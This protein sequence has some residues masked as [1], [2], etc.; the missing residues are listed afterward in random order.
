MLKRTLT[1]LVGMLIFIPVCIFSGTLVFPIAVAVVTVIAV[2]EMMNCIGA[3]KDYSLTVPVYILAVV[4][5]MSARIFKTQGRFVLT[6][7]AVLFLLL[8][9]MFTV[10]VAKKG[11]I[12]I[13]KIAMV[14]VMN[15]Y[16]IT[17]FTSIL[18]LRDKASGKYIY[19]LAILGP[20]VSDIFAYLVGTMLGKH[21]LIPEVSPKK[22]VEGSIGGIV[23]CGILFAL[24]GFV[25]SKIYDT[26]P[27]Y[28]ALII[29]GVL[30]SVISQIGD[31]IASM[32]KRQYHIKDYGK[33]FPGHG[34]VMDRFDSVLATAPFLLIMCS[35]PEVFR[36]FF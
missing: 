23:F 29:A 24:Y 20:W 25:I 31:L 4:V 1:A 15:V 9:Y 36:L 13:E 22:T 7:V 17:A 11:L 26:Q 16:I 28:L 32:I 33:I 5:P 34:G 6:Y 19:L 35:I 2:Y 12:R 10:M 27:E 8:L 30:V 3:T 21:K 14:Y 18:L